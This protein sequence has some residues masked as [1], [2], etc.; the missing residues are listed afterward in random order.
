M[1]CNRNLERRLAAAVALGAMALGGCADQEE[2]LIVLHAVAWPESGECFVD[3]G[4]DT[5]IPRGVADLSVGTGYLAPL[6]L[7][8]QLP[9]S[10]QT[11]TGIENNEMQLRSVEVDLAMPQAPEIIDAL[12]A[13]N[14][15]FV[16]FEQNLASDS[17]GPGERHAASV[18]LIT[19]PAAA[20]MSEQ[21]RNAFPD[22]PNVRLVV[23]ATVVY[24]ALQTGN[25]VGR[26]SEV[27]AR[28]YVFPVE[29][30]NGCLID[31]SACPMG[32]CPSPL[33]A[34]QGGVCGNLQDLPATPAACS[35]G[36]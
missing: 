1:S 25:T 34:L 14:E 12:E 18:D 29:V 19:S 3:A 32:A 21:I 8:N 7:L 15:A 13:Q 28:E 30:C 35:E 22:Q 23:E 26:F 2:S 31:C 10:G 11:N 33:G 6:V 4:S 5:T 20:V 17:I 27:E 9:T 36:M 16:S 24:K